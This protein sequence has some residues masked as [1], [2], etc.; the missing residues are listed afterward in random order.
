MGRDATSSQSLG[1]Q[2]KRD[3]NWQHA[4]VKQPRKPTC[5][6]KGLQ[7]QTVKEGDVFYFTECQ[8]KSD[9]LLQ[10][11]NQELTS[12]TEHT[13]HSHTLRQSCHGVTGEAGGGGCPQEEAGKN[14]VLQMGYWFQ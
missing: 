2:K 11:A 8:K 12:E 4:E 13:Q 5:E 9:S 3:R 6:E 14:R 10:K 7:T 1:A